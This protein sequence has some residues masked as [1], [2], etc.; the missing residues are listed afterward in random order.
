MIG[1]HAR[2]FSAPRQQNQW[3]PARR[4]LNSDECR[5]ERR[6]NQPIIRGDRPSQGVRVIERYD[7]P[8]SVLLTDTGD[9]GP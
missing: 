2:E 7:T 8:A 3:W 5:A 6:L 9:M 1:I 4:A